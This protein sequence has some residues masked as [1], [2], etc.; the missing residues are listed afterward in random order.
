[1]RLAM[2]TVVLE[3]DQ[4]LEVLKKER[5]RILT[6]IPLTKQTVRKKRLIKKFQI[7]DYTIGRMIFFRE[8]FETAG[9]KA[10]RNKLNI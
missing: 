7:I 3:R 4:I 8:D 5:S 10:M 2:F 9:R 1:M 6:V